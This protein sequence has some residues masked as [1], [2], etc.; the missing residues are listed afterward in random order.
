[1]DPARGEVVDAGEPLATLASFRRSPQGK[2]MFGQN[3]IHRAVGT[4]RVGDGVVV[5]ES[6]PA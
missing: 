4:V 1:V 5:R 6:A 3:L 2:V